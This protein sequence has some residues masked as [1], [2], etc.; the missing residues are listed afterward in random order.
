MHTRMLF[1]NCVFPAQVGKLSR[2]ILRNLSSILPIFLLLAIWEIIAQM[3][4]INPILFP[5]LS[6]V[7]YSAFQNLQPET[8]RILIK[9]IYTTFRSITVGFG[10]AVIIGIGLGI[11]MGLTRPIYRFFYPI[12]VITL[13]IPALAWTPLLL[14]WIGFGTKTVSVVAFIAAFFPVAYN[15]LSG[16]RSC[17]KHFIWIAEMVGANK[18]T[19]FFK[20]ILPSSLPYII[21]ALKVGWAKSWRAMIGAEMIA[22]TSLGVGFMIFE[23]REYMNTDIMYSGILFLAIVGVFF[24]KVIF[25]SIEIKTVQKWG[26]IKE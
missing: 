17:S 19:L 24:E 12:I 14:I 15:T 5:K 26:M 6:T 1:K 2:S 4:V 8:D 16:A 11:S 23:A 20:V 21:T 9:H 18:F 13:P 7:L 10:I 25:R 22:A 3:E